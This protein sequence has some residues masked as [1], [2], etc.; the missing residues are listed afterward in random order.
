MSLPR[1]NRCKAIQLFIKLHLQ[2][3]LCAPTR[4]G[5]NPKLN[6]ELHGGMSSK[7]RSQLQGL[8]KRDSRRRTCVQC[9]LSDVD[10]YI[11]GYDDD[12]DGDSPNNRRIQLSD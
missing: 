8:Y 1:P 9:S 11:D 5:K 10:G 6:C 3:P 7:E 4:R 2:P 12:D